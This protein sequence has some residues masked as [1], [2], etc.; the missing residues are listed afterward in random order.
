MTK[1][2]LLLA[3]CAAAALVPA[4]AFADGVKLTPVP[5]AMPKAEG[6]AGAGTVIPNALSPE[7][8]QTVAA[9][10]AMPL[11]NPTALIPAYGYAADGPMVP[12]A[13]AVQGADPIEATKTEPDKNTYLVLAD[14]KGPDAAY[15]YGTHF[16][17]QGHEHGAKTADGGDQGYLSRINLDAD[18]AHR[19]TLMAD[20]TA[21]GQPIL[22][23]DGSTWDPFANRLLL[24]VEEGEPGGVWQATVDFPSKVESL[25]G[26]IGNGAYEG[27]EVDP[28]GAI[29]IVEDWG[30]K[31]GKTAKNAKQP[32]SFVYRFTP[33]DKTDLTKGGKLEALQIIDSTG[34][35]VAYHE[36]QGDAD[37]MSQG[38]KDLHSYGT[39]LKTKWVL[40]HD[41]DGDGMTPFNAN[42]RAKLAGASPFKRPEN[43]VFRPGSDFK[44][45]VFTE[46]GDTNAD[47]EA[48]AAY[49]GFG[50]VLKLSQAAP[51]AAEG[52]IALVFLGD[53][54]HSGFDN[55]AF[56]SA[57]E[58]LVVEDRGD[59]LHDQKNALDSGWVI[60]LAA[61]Y[62]KGDVAPVRFL[63]EGRDTAATIDSGLA[64]LPDTGFQ[65]DGDNEITGI[66]VSDGD[67]S[68]EG[69]L[70]AKI[71]TPFENGWRMFWTQQHGDN[72]TWEVFR[73]DSLLK[74]ASQ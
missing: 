39:A 56:W 30:G 54:E 22:Y 7:L 17:F 71:P 3:A 32:N 72:V 43:G 21:D 26:I 49:G 66:H 74:T 4:G 19:V 53:P 9:Q 68:P 62:A 6:A 15:N 52:E 35:P 64:A 58:V 10:G 23:I 36:G 50:A 2:S 14:Q 41:T 28:D 70:G 31:S 16:L 8:V 65:N 69:L 48:G 40:V 67:A 27:I 44:E 57:D 60:D 34:Q 47:T 24:T 38:M 5:N 29:W 37:I 73:K 13:N 1:R 20:R 18:A 12:P 11:E 51:S 33:K 59:K 61:D 63:A 25:T 55:L 45:F 42:I 46:T